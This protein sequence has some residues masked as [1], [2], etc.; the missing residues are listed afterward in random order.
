MVLSP[1]THFVRSGHFD[2][3]RDAS[4]ERAMRSIASRSAPK[5]I[6]PLRQAYFPSGLQSH[7]LSAAAYAAKAALH[8]KMSRPDDRLLALAVSPISYNIGDAMRIEH[9][10]GESSSIRSGCGGFGRRRDSRCPAEAREA[11]DLGRASSGGWGQCAPNRVE[12]P[13]HLRPGGFGG[14]V[15]TPGGSRSVHAEVFG[16]PG[17]G[18]GDIGSS[19]GGL[20]R[21]GRQSRS[22]KVCPKRQRAGIAGGGIRS[23]AL[24][25]GNSA[26]LCRGG[27]SLGEWPRGRS[28][29]GT[30]GTN[31][32]TCSCAGASGGASGPGMVA[33]GKQ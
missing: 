19:S 27:P 18:W 6:E 21:G 16:D 5:G 25:S 14:E 10:I 29:A 7:R 9:T 11:D 32:R 4:T 1:S 30:C 15:E 26:A 17:A 20:R 23:I 24:G 12:L 33:P 3:R 31:A 13:P 28:S 2:S 8:P 22:S